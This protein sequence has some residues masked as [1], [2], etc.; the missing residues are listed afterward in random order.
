MEL[1]VH[2]LAR[3]EI[4]REDEMQLFE[5]VLEEEAAER[6]RERV[7]QSNPWFAMRNT[8]HEERLKSRFG[9]DMVEAAKL[10]YLR[11]NE[12]KPKTHVRRL[13]EFRKIWPRIKQQ[14]DAM[15]HLQQEYDQLLCA[16]LKWEER[17]YYEQ[18]P[19][20]LSKRSR[21]TMQYY[22]EHENDD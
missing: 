7:R 1:K 4:T 21:E 6:A 13:Q 18:Y 17:G 9:E 15:R 2:F 14:R 12:W 16:E 11:W 20:N 19:Q 22:M 5:M 10:Y 3:S 8:P